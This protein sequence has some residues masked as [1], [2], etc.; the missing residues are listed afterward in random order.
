MLDI[1][2]DIDFSVNMVEPQTF[3][4]FVDQGTVFQRQ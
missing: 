4:A 2:S 3:N 1:H